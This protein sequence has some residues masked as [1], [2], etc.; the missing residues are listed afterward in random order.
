MVTA[1][2]RVSKYKYHNYNKMN[3]PTPEQHSVPAP[4]TRTD[5]TNWRR[6]TNRRII[7]HSNHQ[8]GNVKRGKKL[9]CNNCGFFGH[10]YNSCKQPVYSYGVICFK[11]DIN[12]EPKYLMIQRRNSISMV[13]FLIK[14]CNCSTVR[15]P[16]SAASRRAPGSAFSP[17]I[18][19]DVDRL[20]VMFSRMTLK[21]R[22]LIADTIKKP[23]TAAEI[24]R[25]LL[26]KT[27]LIGLAERF[28]YGKNCRH[29]TS[30]LKGVRLFNGQR[31][32]L[33]KDYL[34]I[35]VL[36]R[37]TK[38]H[39]KDPEW[40]FPK[41]RRNQHEHDIKCATREFEEES[42]LET[43]EYK[44]IDFFMPVS[45]QYMGSNGINYQAIF[46]FAEF[47]GDHTVGDKIGVR[48]EKQSYEIGDVRW[49][50]YK[51]CM[52]YIR[53]YTKSRKMVLTKA[54]SHVRKYIEQDGYRNTLYRYYPKVVADC[55][56]E[57]L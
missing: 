29:F 14:I 9:Y 40:G 30:L 4:P 41:G 50:S 49:F 33:P 23:I 57:C 3:A 42:G 27:H 55:A 26:E 5:A 43:K 51:E 7:V 15:H 8:S 16:P 2:N 6:P 47:T 36:L 25:T 46:Y 17:Q 37:N 31:G 12:G 32:M 19:W 10:S 28:D 56:V 18:R 35:E 54:N 11:R 21:E 1:Y 48:S 53:D 38:S 34:S 45:E 39:Y 13:E 24:Y 52:E 22:E 20:M 44:V